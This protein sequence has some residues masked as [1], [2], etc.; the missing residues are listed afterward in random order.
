MRFEKLSKKTLSWFIFIFTLPCVNF[1]E[2]YNVYRKIQQIR[3]VRPCLLLKNITRSSLSIP[4][5][6]L[7]KEIYKK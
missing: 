6:H 5:V 1:P 2:K 7:V 3:P 4:V